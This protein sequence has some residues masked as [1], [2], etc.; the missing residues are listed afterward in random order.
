MR[1][2]NKTNRMKVIP[3]PHHS[4]CTALGRCMCIQLPGMKK[5]V[6]TSLTIP[7]GGISKD[8]PNA[9]LNV[10]QVARLLRQQKL[11]IVG[12]NETPDKSG[13]K[14]RRKR[15]PAAKTAEDSESSKTRK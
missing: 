14:T 3:L 7:A 1:L 5:K 15:R 10:A 8:M 2:I 13:K 9:V 11:E 12:N 4:Y 6:A